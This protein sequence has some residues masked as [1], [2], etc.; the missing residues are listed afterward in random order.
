MPCD[1]QQSDTASSTPVSIRLGFVDRGDQTPF[2][3][4]QYCKVSIRLGFV[5]RGDQTGSR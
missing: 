2:P 5:D 1:T 3:T 4:K